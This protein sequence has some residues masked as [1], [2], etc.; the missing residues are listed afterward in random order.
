MQNISTRDKSF[1]HKLHRI[2]KHLQ[3]EQDLL[4]FGKTFEVVLSGQRM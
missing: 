2:L 3:P 4:F 1:V